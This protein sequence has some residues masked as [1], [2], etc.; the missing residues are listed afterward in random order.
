[1][2]RLE[3]RNLPVALAVGAPVALFLPVGSVPPCSWPAGPYRRLRPGLPRTREHQ[4]MIPAAANWQSHMASRV[5]LR[6]PWG[7]P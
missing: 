1:M 4:S 5:Y 3:V 6:D 7:M 2:S